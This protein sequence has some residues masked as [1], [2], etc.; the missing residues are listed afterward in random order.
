MKTIQCSSSAAIIIYNT[1]FFF[2]SNNNLFMALPCPPPPILCSECQ[3]FR[4]QKEMS[5]ACAL[6]GAHYCIKLHSDCKGTCTFCGI[7]DLC[8]NCTGFARCC[9]TFSHETG[10]VFVGREAI[11]ELQRN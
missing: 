10:F 1:M 11:I 7:Q 2:C 9:H 5:N 3:V 6:C 8:H 4:P